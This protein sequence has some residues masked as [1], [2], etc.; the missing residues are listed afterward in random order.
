VALLC[1]FLFERLADE[2]FEGD[3]RHVDDS[4]RAFVHSIANPGLT[5]FMEFVS[6]I[7]S[8]VPTVII[9]LAIALVLWATGRR[10][11]AIFLALTAAGAE[12]LVITLKLLFQ[13]HRPEPFFGLPAPSDYSFPSGH[14]LVS[15]CFYGV[16]AYGIAHRKSLPIRTLIWTLAAL[17]I[18]LVGLSRIYLGVHYPSDVL[19]G[20]L[21]A[22][23]WVLGVSLAY[24]RWERRREKLKRAN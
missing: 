17:L 2:V 9:G 20:Y 21:A 12:I 5:A 22:T 8:A 23:A 10:A 7:A 18:L 11:H 1:L 13:R 14:A 19:A 3:T 24:A 16:I 6:W 15:L 4:F